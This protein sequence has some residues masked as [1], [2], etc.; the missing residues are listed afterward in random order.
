MKTSEDDR[1]FRLAMI[2][3]D[4]MV[5]PR[6]SRHTTDIT[7]PSGISCPNSALTGW[8]TVTNFSCEHEAAKAITNKVN[9]S[10]LIA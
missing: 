6:A 3:D 5:P 2:C 4:V 1:S 8:S 7:E 10:F 9:I